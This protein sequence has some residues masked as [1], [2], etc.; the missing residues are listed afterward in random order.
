L[1]TTIPATRL[2][3]LGMSKWHDYQVSIIISESCSGLICMYC[4]FDFGLWMKMIK[5]HCPSILCQS[6][7]PVSIFSCPV[8]F[9]GG[10][11]SIQITVQ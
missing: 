3:H 7:I 6:H 4:S 5:F 8:S 11:N 9:L 1:Q 10:F 2:I